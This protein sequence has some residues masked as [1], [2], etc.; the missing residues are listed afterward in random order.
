[1]SEQNQVSEIDTPLTPSD[2]VEENAAP[3]VVD[4]PAV[5]EAEAPA[6]VEAVTEPATAAEAVAE[7]PLA[8][9]PAAEV[10]TSEAASPPEAPD[11][12]SAEQVALEAQLKLALKGLLELEPDDFG[13]RLEQSNLLELTLLMEEI[14]TLEVDRHLVRKI[15][16]LR[17]RYDA[18]YQ[19]EHALAKETA[20]EEQA[21]QIRSEAN[22]CNKRYIAALARFN[23]GKAEFEARDQKQKEENSARKRALIEQLKT[24]VKAEEVTAIEAVRK[25][26][27]EWREIGPV[28]QQDVEDIYQ[29]YRTYCDQFYQMRERY[30]DLVEQDRKV[31]LE[32]KEKIIQEVLSLIPPEGIPDIPRNYWQEATD[33]IRIL[34]ENWKSIG[35]VPR[36]QSEDI[37]QRFKDVTDLFYKAKREFFSH[38][39]AERAQSGATKAQILERLE[40]YADIVYESIDEWRQASDIVNGLRDEW[41]QA[42]PAPSDQNA[43]FNNRYKQIMDGFF[44]RRSAYFGELDS[45]KDSVV[46][47]KQKLLDQ[48]EALKDSDD[49]G[50]TTDLLIQLQRE[51]TE[52]GPD[53]FKD[54]RKLQ[55]RFRKA[56]DT[57]FRRKKEHFS[58]L[59]EAEEENLR[60]KSAICEAIEQRIAQAREQGTDLLDA[61]ELIVF[62]E[63]FDEAGR[64]PIKAK[65]KITARFQAAFNTYLELAI[66]DSMQRE[67]FVL[68]NRLSAGNRGGGGGG[69]RGQRGERGG[70]DRGSDRNYERSERFER[71]IPSAGPLSAAD[72]EERKYQKKIKML[73]EEIGQYE[74]NFFFISQSKSSDTFRKDIESKIAQAKTLKEQL[75]G[76]LKALRDLKKQPKA[77]SAP[78]EAEVLAAVAETITS[79]EVS[80]EPTADAPEE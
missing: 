10:P 25:I 14:G 43:A 28:L 60:Q 54:A 42:G 47:V 75:E 11:E 5:S 20:D 38:L 22:R 49:W 57:F 45:Q 7:T 8:A 58:S 36:A 26:Q 13:T 62:K 48:A 27:E 51:W 64:V 30:L 17:R 9:G 23:K 71:N 2:P 6:P 24:V 63:Q 59:R 66:P 40:P 4:T 16:K 29:T 55:K 78:E 72:L 3:P 73:E 44:E 34:H 46:T 70:Y 33:R 52:S 65:E 50:T 79:D 77:E 37:W 15:A 69:G 61:D 53:S 80:I 12:I 18:V 32:E 68:R 35:P 19:N 39:D 76:R 56:C 67:K 41:R 31:N 74:N 1:M 21:R